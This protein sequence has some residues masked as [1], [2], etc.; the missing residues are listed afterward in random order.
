VSVK[1]FTHKGFYGD[2]RPQS[3]GF[4]HKN[5]DLRV[6]KHT[7]EIAETKLPRRRDVP[8]AQAMLLFEIGVQICDS[9]A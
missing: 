5:S 9:G 8:T 6:K 4:R 1:L 2:R 7:L 3:V